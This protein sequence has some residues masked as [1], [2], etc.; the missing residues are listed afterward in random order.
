MTQLF[1]PVFSAK[2][3]VFKVLNNLLLKVYVLVFL[4]GAP[5]SIRHF[6]RPSV[7]HHISGIVHMTVI[8]GAY[9]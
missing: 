9:V 6:F 4:G 1:K 7:V 8:Y 5:A 3:S 2:V